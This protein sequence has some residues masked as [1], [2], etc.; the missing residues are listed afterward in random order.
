MRHNQSRATADQLAMQND[1]Q[2]NRA[3]IP[4]LATLTPELPFGLL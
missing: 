2:V 1:V 4:T 3:G